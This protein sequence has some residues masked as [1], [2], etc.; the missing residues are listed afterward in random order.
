MLVLMTYV[1]R[2]EHTNY[3]IICLEE[4]AQPKKNSFVPVNS[5]MESLAQNINYNN[6]IMSKIEHLL[7]SQHTQVPAPFNPMINQMGNN[8]FNPM[9]IPMN[10]NMNM[11]NPN[12]INQFGNNFG[13]MGQMGQMG[14]YNFNNM[15]NM[16]PMSM[17]N[18]V[19]QPQ[20]PQIRQNPQIPQF[21]QMQMMNGNMNMYPGAYMNGNLAANPMMNNMRLNY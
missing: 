17:N 5:Y 16:N 7:E 21:P 9:N 11:I 6:M 18:M 20:I 1:S 4:V 19:N 3:L 8:F 13:Q 2:R 15:M 14:N 10:M 12:Q